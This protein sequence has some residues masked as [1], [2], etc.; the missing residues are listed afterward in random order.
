MIVAVTLKELRTVLQPLF[1][2]LFLF[3]LAAPAVNFLVRRRVPDGAAYLI[4]LGGFAALAVAGLAGLADRVDDFARRLPE[5]QD[6]LQ[7]LAVSTAGGVTTD[8]P[9]FRRHTR[10]LAAHVDVL[11]AA[12][13]AAGDFLAGLMTFF[14]GAVLVT[15]YI[16]FLIHESRTLPGR[17]V[18]IYGAE[19]A[20]R[21]AA[22]GERIH[23]SIARY[24]YVKLLASLLTAAT[25]LV[26]MLAFGLD[27][28]V[29]WAVILLAFNF[30][31]YVGSIVAFT[32]PV[33]MG[34]LQFAEA[35]KVALMT[36]AFIAIDVFVGNYWEPRVG[37]QKL[38]V[39]PILILFSLAFWGFLWGVTGMILSVPIT[40]SIAFILQNIP[41]TRP[42]GLLLAYRVDPPPE[43]DKSRPVT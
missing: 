11:K 39:S 3:Y 20:E 36:A 27:F 5:M 6:R 22:V 35:W 43:R 38:N 10:S 18:A 42:V 33:G 26:V 14:G 13:G 29:L 25:S 31:P 9:F 40:V 37:G 7:S 28:A 15:F 23:K 19:Q 8:M 34:I 2:A 4:V 30:I 32:F 16:A 21:I 24:I 12:S 17:L 1:I 41:Y